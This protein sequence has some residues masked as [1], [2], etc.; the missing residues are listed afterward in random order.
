M[1]QKLTYD[2][3]EK[4]FFGTDEEIYLQQPL[5]NQVDL[6]VLDRQLPA[7]SRTDK[8]FKTICMFHMQ[9]ACRQ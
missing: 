6:S 3:I 2:N 7:E 4:S 1:I 5:S 8:D 9:K